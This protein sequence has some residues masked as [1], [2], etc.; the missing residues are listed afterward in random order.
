MV[1]ETDYLRYQRDQDQFFRDLDDQLKAERRR[2]REDIMNQRP[3][4]RGLERDA[5]KICRQK[6]M[7][8]A[9]AKSRASS[10]VHDQIHE[11]LDKAL[12]SES[13]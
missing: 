5:V 11:M 9:D 1:D 6:S 7:S 2:I 3:A 12:N 8:E 4:W 10:W 13:E